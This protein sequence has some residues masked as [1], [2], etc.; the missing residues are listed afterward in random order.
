MA[1]MFDVFAR[2]LVATVPLMIIF[3]G[4]AGL[5]RPGKQMGPIGLIAGLTLA[6]LF[7]NAPIDGLLSA[8]LAGVAWVVVVFCW[9]IFGAFFFLNFLKVSKIMEHVKGMFV[10]K[11]GDK[12]LDIILVGFSFALLLGTI[13]PGGSNF[14][15]S[16]SILIAAG[17]DPASASVVGMFGNGIQ[18][19]YGLLGISIY[20]ISYVTGL[21]L[22]SISGTTALMMFPFVIT[23]PLW[24]VLL[25]DRRRPLQV[26]VPALLTGLTYGTVAIL[27]A[28]YLGP[29][30]PNLLAG[31]AAIIPCALWMR[32][33]E[34][35]SFN[36]NAEAVLPFLVMAVL[37]L[38]T[39]L[40]P[41]LRSLLTS[42]QLSIKLYFPTGQRVTFQYLYSPGTLMIVATI[43]CALILNVQLSLMKEVLKL[44]AGQ[45]IPLLISTSSFVAMA[46]VMKTF[47]MTSTMAEAVAFLAGTYYPLVSPVVGMLG[48]V[49]TGSTSASN[50]FFGAFQVEV[51]ERL[52]ISKRV[53]AATQNVG[54]MA[55][56]VLSPL[57]AIVIVASLDMKGEEG[58]LIRRNVFTSLLYLI[59]AGALSLLFSS[60]P[61]LS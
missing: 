49:V 45:I 61:T 50:I 39:R 1:E 46:E 54:S 11:G 20:S 2:A 6:H 19:P 41:P 53:M 31:A 8:S 10:G 40:T 23:A 17:V 16:S 5:K 43:I 3:V 47:G 36:I 28:T 29:E 13:A 7:W 42:Q 14:A 38:T 25:Y 9:S 27:V 60:T 34:G 15:I 18:S 32:L 59:M 55:G 22:S 30:L 52:G 44:S 35:R 33:K 56:E 58:T 24:M 57:N 51:A 26:V 21:E 37:I 12:R 48:C 4:L